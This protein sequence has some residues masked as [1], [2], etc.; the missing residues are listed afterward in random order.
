MA[1]STTP[2]NKDCKIGA[3]LALENSKRH[4]Q[5]A[6][7]LNEADEL[8]VAV[9][10]L[11][12]SVEEAIKA[13]FLYMKGLGIPIRQEAL[14]DFLYKHKPR[15]EAGKF[16]YF[17]FSIFQWMSGTMVAVYEKSVNRTDQEILQIRNEVFEKI[18]DE[19]K[20]AATSHDCDTEIDRI[21]LPVVQWWE[22]ADDKKITGFYVDFLKGQWSSPDLIKKVDYLQSL[23][24]AKNV[25]ELIN[26]GVES[27]EALS[28][29]ER[30]EMV[31]GVKKQYRQLLQANPER[32]KSITKKE[33][34][35][36][37]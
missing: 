29:K 36:I 8:G 1:I 5:C 33:R 34:R 7:R 37:K 17:I 27:I 9:S 26:R 22:S 20:K 25:I 32:A 31:K 6:I 16:F 35:I 28:E 10:H 4:Y 30:S 13:V 15:H 12:L 23:D 18:F 19:F 3:K 11:V 21:V 24:I 2:S 14:N